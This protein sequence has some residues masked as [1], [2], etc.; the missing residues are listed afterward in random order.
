M[1]KWCDS[2]SQKL[3]AKAEKLALA[4]QQCLTKPPGALGRLEDIAVR[5]A[6]MQ[7]QECPTLERIHISVFAADHGV[8]AERVSAFPQAVTREMVKNFVAG[9]AAISVLARQQGATLEI[10]DTGICGDPL[11][12]VGV[13]NARIAAGSANF[14]QQAAMDEDQLQSALAIGQAAVERALANGAQLFIA[15]EMGIANTCSATAVACALLDK[16]A[17]ELAG[18][19]T[20]LDES[21]VAHKAT[22]IDAAVKLHAAEFLSPLFVLRSLGGFEIAAIVGAYLAAA[23]RGLPV[24]VDGY[25]ASVAA[26]VAKQIQPNAA[27]WWFY[28]HV[29]AEPG[30]RAIMDALDGQPL[31]DLG[32]RLG[33]GSG[34][35]IAVPLLQQACILHSQMATFTQAGVSEK[36]ES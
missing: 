33:E 14:S 15:G 34:A 1:F 30:H 7:G 20:G 5:L 28:A 31:L 17:V 9:G 36:T 22:V 21:G 23:Q 11:D 29:S 13:I 6:A 24:L 35:A 10:I 18:P 2:P 3:N 4:R 19:G 16:P 25:I 12:D 26:L 8:A 27:D 32:M